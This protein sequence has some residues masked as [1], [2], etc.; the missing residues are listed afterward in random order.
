V[1]VL[2]ALHLGGPLRVGASRELPI[3]LSMMLAWWAV[4]RLGPRVLDLIPMLSLVATSLSLRLVFEENLYGYYFMAVAV[5]L[6]L[7][8]VLR[9][10]L[11]GF[12]VGWLAMVALVFGPLP[13]GLGP[14]SQEVL[15]RVWQVVLVAPALVW[16]ARPLVSS[17]LSSRAAEPHLRRDHRPAFAG[18]DRRQ[19]LRELAAP[20][21]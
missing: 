17:V 6:L 9:G 11:S 21:R 10:R 16:A 1:T 19:A 3:V 15:L 2:G 7:L 5:A 14:L 20:D 8:D 13:W 18:T 12:L 4:R